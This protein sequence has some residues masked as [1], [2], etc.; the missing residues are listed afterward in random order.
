MCVCVGS[1]RF[2]LGSNVRPLSH[3]HIPMGLGF[4]LERKERKKRGRRK[5]KEREKDRKK[6]GQKEKRKERKRKKEKQYDRVKKRQ[7]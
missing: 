6:E 1:V 4:S 5:K 2:S 7:L 3:Q